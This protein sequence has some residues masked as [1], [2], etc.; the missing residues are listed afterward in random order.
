MTRK[1]E[2]KLRQAFARLDA[3][4]AR[5]PTIA[6]RGR[7]AEACS[8][9]PLSDLEATRL[10]ARTGTL[11]RTIAR[12]D[13]Q[14]CVY[15]TAERRCRVY[16]ERPLMCRAY[17]LLKRLSCPYGCVPDRWLSDLEFV[18][19]AAAIE[20]FAGGR[21]LRTDSTGLT[22]R[23]GESYTAILQRAQAAGVRTPADIEAEAERCRSLR[24]LHG[25][26]ILL[27]LKDDEPRPLDS[28]EEPRS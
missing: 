25:G 16:A 9:I 24:S 7:C 14:S 2:R 19:I 6:C 5:L 11:P 26:R 1:A 28:L 23:V 21:I 13:H 8:A 15:L 22:H 17:G 12:D 4:Y 20:R 3:L 18:A 10:Q 27:A